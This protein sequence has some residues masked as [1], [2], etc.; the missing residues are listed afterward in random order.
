MSDANRRVIRGFFQFVVGLAAGVPL[1]VQA[2]GI[3]ETTAGVG[4]ALA[5]GLG[6]TR[7]M[8]LPVVDDL[9]PSWLRASGEDPALTAAYRERAQLLAL[10]A[11]IYPS[12]M[13]PDPSEPDWPVL[14]LAL[15]TG[16]AT[17]HIAPDDLALFGHVRRDLREVWDGHTT[18]EKYERVAAE[19]SARAGARE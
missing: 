18:A 12:H 11:A 1:I 16:Q 6:L 10:L 5:V 17:W 15:S 13:Q 4:T 3:P 8:A 9:L 19:A 14:Y 7:V 2:S